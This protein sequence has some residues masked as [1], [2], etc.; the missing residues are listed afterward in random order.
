MPKQALLGSSSR[1]R[2]LL[3]G[4]PVL[5]GAFPPLCCCSLLVGLCSMM[6][7][8][9]KCLMPNSFLG[10]RKILVVSAPQLRARRTWE[11]KL[12][13]CF[14][15]SALYTPQYNAGQQQQ[16]SIEGEGAKIGFQI[17]IVISIYSFCNF[18]FFLQFSF[19]L[20]NAS[21]E[22]GVAA[23]I[24]TSWAWVLFSNGIN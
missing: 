22:H 5:S 15:Q 24:A 9:I 4:T 23:S 11:R 1:R 16:C 21:Q 17:I 12:L 14:Q 7:V 20:T 3:H 2:L 18:Q 8:M 19:P 6:K 13:S 10:I